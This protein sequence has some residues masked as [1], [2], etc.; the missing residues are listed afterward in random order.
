MVSYL[1]K[2]PGYKESKETYGQ[3]RG[4]SNLEMKHDGK[5][6]ITEAV[7]CSYHARSHLSHIAYS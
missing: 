3:T 4:I 6:A 7:T 2:F 1:R 5:L